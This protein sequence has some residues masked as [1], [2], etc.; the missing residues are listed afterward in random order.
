MTGARYEV[1]A[2]G[3]GLLATRLRV[4]CME[5]TGWGIGS[6]EHEDEELLG[7]GAIRILNIKC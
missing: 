2:T 7:N 6:M 4:L 3:Y 5:S 1:R